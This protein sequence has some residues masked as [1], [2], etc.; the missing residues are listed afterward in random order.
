MPKKILIVDDDKSVGHSLAILL[1]EEGYLV[2]NTM[3]SKEGALL[4][5]KD[6]YDVCLFDYKMKGLSGIDLLKM[7]KN[8][9]PRC[10][11]FIISGMLDIDTLY[12][13]ENI[14]SLVAG[15]INKPFDIEELFQKI[16]HAGPIQT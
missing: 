2:D 15:V 3:D 8:K 12:A 10:A 1:R 6:G 4:I 9:H 14:R 16:R 11:V 7:T 5:E 13:D